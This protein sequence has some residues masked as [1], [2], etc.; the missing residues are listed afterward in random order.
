MKHIVLFSGGCASSYVAHMVIEEF[1]RRDVILLH[2]PTFSEHRDA[3]RFRCQVARHLKMPTTQW[4]DGRD[5]WQIIEDGHCLPS[6]FIPFCTQQL[7][8]KMKA[9]FL[10]TLDDDYTEYVGFGM[11]EWQRVQRSSARAESEGKKV[12]F[13]LFE[14]KISNTEVKRIIREEWK[15][16]LP[17]VYKYLNHNNCIPCFKAGKKSWR[18]YL[19]HWPE[20]FQKA[21]EAEKAIGHTVF[22]DKSL[23]E[24]AKEWAV[25]SCQL[26]LF[27]GVPCECWSE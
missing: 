18:A 21:V 27:D 17:S 25:D 4:G 24:L 20:E 14:Q 9:E 3:D 1:G 2:T 16:E 23:E 12:R 15:I 8:Q 26:D 19:K 5:I 11:D 13:P 10:K 6:N 22:K 7:K